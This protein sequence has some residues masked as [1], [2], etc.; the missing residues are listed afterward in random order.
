MFGLRAT[1]HTTTQASPMQLVFNRDAI[2]NLKFHA[3]W[4]FIRDRKQKI[5]NANNRRENSRRRDY[6][7]QVGDNVLL[8]G[9]SNTKY[10]GP[11]YHG[12]Y[13]ILEISKIQKFIVS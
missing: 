2:L 6:N 11:Q 9:N 5:I 4:K 3:D 7:Y 12:P 13:Q 8:L 10:G 1:F